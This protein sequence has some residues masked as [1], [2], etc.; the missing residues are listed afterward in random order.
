MKYT[1]LEFLLDCK[2]ALAV[3]KSQNPQVSPATCGRGEYSYESILHA[4]C[5]K[6]NDQL[7]TR[8]KTPTMLREV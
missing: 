5:Q 6:I 4:H 8:L 7:K 2:K 3:Y 1:P